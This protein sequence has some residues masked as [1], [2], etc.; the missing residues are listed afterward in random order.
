MYTPAKFKQTQWEEIC[1]FIQANPLATLIANTE[2]GLEAT[3]IPLLWKENTS[4][5]GCLYGHFAKGNS[6]WKKSIPEQEWLIIF[7]DVGH[8]I[9]A[10]YYPSKLQDHKV[11]PTWNYQAIHLKA[12]IHLIDDIE[13]M[14]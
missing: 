6:I 8:Y 5:F 14:K 1:R 2:N 9:S 11:V 7:H 12:K 3:H 13:K 4:E 10:N